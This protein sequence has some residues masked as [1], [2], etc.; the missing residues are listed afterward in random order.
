MLGGIEPRPWLPLVFFECSPHWPG[1]IH[2]PAFWDPGNTR[3]EYEQVAEDTNQCQ[4]HQ[5]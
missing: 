3:L 1:L 2:F 4:H 5:Y